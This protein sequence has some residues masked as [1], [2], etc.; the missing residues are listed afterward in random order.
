ML[1]LMKTKAKQNGKVLASSGSPGNLRYTAKWLG[2]SEVVV[3]EHGVVV[4]RYFTK[5][6]QTARIGR[7]PNGFALVVA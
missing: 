2:W 1:Y 5:Q 6:A 3:Q 4:D 7:H